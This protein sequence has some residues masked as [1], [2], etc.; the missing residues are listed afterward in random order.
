[1]ENSHE[2]RD[3]ETLLARPLCF[4]TP[5]E[6]GS[7]PEYLAET[8]L[9]PGQRNYPHSRALMTISD[10]R[11]REEDFHL[12]KHSFAALPGAVDELMIDFEREEE[13]SQKYLP[14]VENLLMRQV[15]GAAKVVIFDHCLRKASATKTPHR[16]VHKIHIDQSPKG[17]FSR[18]VKHLPE[19]DLR[20]LSAGKMS[21]KIINVWKPVKRRVSDHPL[22]FVDFESL[23]ADD[24][25]PVRQVYPTYV[26]ETYAVKHNPDHRFYYWSDME[27][28]DVLL[29]QCFDSTRREAN[30]GKPSYVQCAHGSFEL[31]ELDEPYN[32]ESIE[33]RC[34]VLINSSSAK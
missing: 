24:L 34:I 15:P 9:H 13:V 27:T 23:A 10:I 3:P 6:D 30:D 33:V 14:W 7:S 21:F 4:Y 32:R 18:A 22:T 26:G 2:E 5:P 31:A 25:V 19:E 28:T 16:Q 11:G 20:A 12:A 17:A 1:M 29:L 8:P